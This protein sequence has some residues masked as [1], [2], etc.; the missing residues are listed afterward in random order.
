[1]V[2]AL[3]HNRPSAIL[4]I[5]LALLR[6]MLWTVRRC[7][8]PLRG[9]G[10]CVRIMQCGFISR[11]KTASEHSNGL[12]QSFGRLPVYHSASSPG[13]GLFSEIVYQFMLCSLVSWI[14]TYTQTKQA[15]L[16]RMMSFLT[17]PNP[18]KLVFTG[19]LSLSSLRWVPAHG[20]QSHFSF[21]FASF[22]NGEISNQQQKG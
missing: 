14:Y 3:A 1:M 17:L 21:Y 22:C 9:D 12:S 5:L 20:F 2:N 19:K 18:V 8:R 13:S 11:S 4:E 16:M 6:S 15:K 7:C 10:L